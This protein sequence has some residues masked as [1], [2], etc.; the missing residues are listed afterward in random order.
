MKAIAVT[1]AIMVCVMSVTTLKSADAEDHL[2]L[3]SRA[4]VALDSSRPQW[5]IA[6][7]PSGQWGVVGEA[8]AR[9]TGSEPSIPIG[10]D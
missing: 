3:T 8:I 2:E 7:E 5:P 10:A 9:H 1:S 6:R 4:S